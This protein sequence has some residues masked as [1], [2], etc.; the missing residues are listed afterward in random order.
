[1]FYHHKS[2]GD[3]KYRSSI[4]T[5]RSKLFNASGTIFSQTIPSKINSTNTAGSKVEANH[6]EIATRV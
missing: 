3:D 2:R 4:I 1:M 6:P 5:G